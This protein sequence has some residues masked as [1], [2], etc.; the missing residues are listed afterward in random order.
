MDRDQAYRLALVLQARA[1]LD[2]STWVARLPRQVSLLARGR[3][4]QIV[5]GARRGE[6]WNAL[7][8]LTLALTGKPLPA[9]EL[10]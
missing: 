1:R 8:E 4:D 3:A 5:K 2:A 6:A 10:P 7:L 9:A